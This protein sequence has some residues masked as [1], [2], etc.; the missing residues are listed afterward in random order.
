MI[1]V[2]LGINM[3]VEDLTFAA[4]DRDQTTTSRNY[5]ADIAG[6]RYFI[7]QPALT[8][9]DEIDARMRSGELALAILVGA[10]LYLSRYQDRLI[11]V[12]LAALAL[13]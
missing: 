5:I 13:V 11:E 6:S 7:E 4:L 10:I 3:D 1:V 9:Y 12:E 8:S 2:G